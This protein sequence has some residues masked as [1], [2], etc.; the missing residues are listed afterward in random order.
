MNIC[1]KMRL[2]IERRQNMKK[3]QYLQT[4][5]KHELDHIRQLSQIEEERQDFEQFEKNTKKDPF[6]IF[7]YDGK[8]LEKM[9]QQVYP[10]KVEEKIRLL[11]G[12]KYIYDGS[13]KYENVLMPQL[14]ETKKVL[15]TIIDDICTFS[16]VFYKKVEQEGKEL[17]KNYQAILTTVKANEYLNQTDSLEYILKKSELPLE[18]Q[19]QILFEVQDYN[20]S[21]FKT[22]FEQKQA[23]AK[24]K[25]VENKEMKENKSQEEIPE[26]PA[27]E[28]EPF[29][30]PIPEESLEEQ[31]M[32]E[33]ITEEPIDHFDEVEEEL[34]KKE[35][36]YKEKEYVETTYREP[37]NLIEYE[38]ETKREIFSSKEE[39]KKEKPEKPSKIEPVEPSSY[40]EDYIKIL[41]TMDPDEE[42]A[43]YQVLPAY[44]MPNFEEL[45]EELI[46]YEESRL[47]EDENASQFIRVMKKYINKRNS[48]RMIDAKKS[49]KQKKS[50]QR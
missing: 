2:I 45:M 31:P 49:W 40:I 37:E 5:L 30:N 27:Y 38:E 15:Q 17:E 47:E 34:P 32:Q 23:E 11:Y 10:D 9:L 26:E 25:K 7:K 12:A 24:L 20:T 42:Y 50:A 16:H 8:K 22:L 39:T 28:E 1:D 44:S 46:A 3:L 4:L 35:A 6:C 43:I 48:K 21:I 36:Y 19:L 41:E 29:E 14:E 18:N 13:R 33:E